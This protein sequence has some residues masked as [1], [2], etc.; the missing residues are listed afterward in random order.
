M[1]EWTLQRAAYVFL[2]AVLPP[3]SEVQSNDAASSAGLR[4]RQAAAA[5]GVRAGWPD[6]VC[7]VEGFPAIYPEAK[8]PG[9]RL[10][11]AQEARGNNLLRL[12]RHWFVFHSLAELEQELRRIGVP[13]RGTTLS[14]GERDQ[15]LAVRAPAKKATKPRTTRPKPADLARVAGMRKAVMF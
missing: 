14:A 15:R 9:G 11:P 6:I 13:L 4:Q 3:G 10:T 1:N 12:G 8:M 2:C 5:R 7:E